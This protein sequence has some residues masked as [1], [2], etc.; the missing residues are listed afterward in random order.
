MNYITPSSHPTLWRIHTLISESFCADPGESFPTSVSHE[1]L[2]MAETKLSTLSDDDV[3]IISG[4]ELPDGPE[5]DALINTPEG[6]IVVK[7]FGIE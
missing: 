2:S 4:T 3:R 1:E 7:T 6:L 5:F